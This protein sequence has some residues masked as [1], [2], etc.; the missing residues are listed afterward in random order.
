MAETKTAATNIKSE[1]SKKK[2]PEKWEIED[3]ARTLMRADDIRSDRKMMGHVSRHVDE[4]QEK[5]SRMKK[6]GLVSEKG[7]KV[8]KEKAKSRGQ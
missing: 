5:L 7:E 1:P 6:L 8:A 2:F 4:Q 3:A